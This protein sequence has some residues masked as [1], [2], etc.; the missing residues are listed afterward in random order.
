MVALS[1]ATGYDPKT[2]FYTVRILLELDL[3]Y[4]PEHCARGKALTWPYP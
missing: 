2:C 4:V 1:R 3:V